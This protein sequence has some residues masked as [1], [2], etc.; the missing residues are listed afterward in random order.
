M[1]RIQLN[2]EHRH[3]SVPVD[4]L[5]DP[6]LSWKAKGLLCM[7]L[8]AQD[9]EPLARLLDSATSD[10]K[11][12][13]A[14]AIAELQKEGYLHEVAGTVIVYASPEVPKIGRSPGRSTRKSDKVD[15]QSTSENRQEPSV[16]TSE[17]RNNF[18]LE[19]AGGLKGGREHQG[20]YFKEGEYQ[21]HAKENEL[22]PEPA[23]PT[24]GTM[25]ETNDN[26]LFPETEDSPR[27][28]RNSLVNT[29]DKMVV[30]FR[31]EEA[32]G[33]NIR[34]YF[35]SVMDWSETGGSKNKPQKRTSRGW[36]A[37]MRTWMRS[38][39]AKGKLVR[40]AGQGPDLGNFFKH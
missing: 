36:V 6:R 34:H 20:E 30:H 40:V 12:A 3:V 10:G 26:S 31:E 25:P 35:D 19:L 18:K 9:G 14:S 23:V 27:L 15:Q 5:R 29:Y 38:D 13:T 24:E 2:S 11:A 28:L 8:T 16:G 4:M 39:N 1:R 21:P 32:A 17:N 22:A 33:I 7:L 37:T